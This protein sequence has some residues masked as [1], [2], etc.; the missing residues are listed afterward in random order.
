VYIATFSIVVIV[1]LGAVF[2]WYRGGGIERKLE[3]AITKGNLLN[4][5]GEN[6]YELYKQLKESGAD[7]K[8]LAR[9]EEK[10]L[11]MLTSRGQQALN[12]FAVPSNQ[13]PALAEWEE[14]HKLLSWASEIKSNDNTLIA[15]SNYCAGRIAYLANRKDEAFKLWKLASEQDTSWAMPTN[16]IGLIYNERKDYSTARQYLFEAT[17]REPDWAVP[18]NNIGTSFFFERDYTQAEIYYRRAV[19]RDQRWGRPHFWL[20]DIAY[21][22]QNFSLAVEEYEGGLS[23]TQPSATNLDLS[24]IRTKLEQARQKAAQ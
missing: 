7:G 6:A 23:L 1:V 3:G 20:G 17:R 15:K 13:E 24:K 18:Y 5:P 9:F 11:P 16:G 22:N 8:T 12:T 2:Y 21:Q 19:E 14:A 10:L 4:P